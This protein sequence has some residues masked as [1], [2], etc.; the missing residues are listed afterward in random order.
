MLNSL[1]PVGGTP[2]TNGVREVKR[3]HAVEAATAVK[4]ETT[5]IPAS[6]PAEVLQA[7]DQAAQTLAELRAQQINLKFEVDDSTRRVKVTVSDGEGRVLRQVPANDLG[8][9]LA[10]G[11]RS[12]LVVDARG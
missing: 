7:M 6:P 12:G 4:P 9:F 8:A 2:T 3:A 5:A 11:G 1:S 10:G